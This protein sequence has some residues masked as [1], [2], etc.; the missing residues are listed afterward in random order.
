MRRTCTSRGSERRI[1]SVAASS[2]SSQRLQTSARG[3]LH[4]PAKAGWK[5]H[6]IDGRRSGSTKSPS[7][8]EA[9][10]AA[11]LAL[12]PGERD[13]ERQRLVCDRPMAEYATGRERPSE[14]SRSRAY[15]S[16]RRWSPRETEGHRQPCRSQGL[17]VKRGSARGHV[18]RQSFGWASGRGSH[19]PRRKSKTGVIRESS[20]SQVLVL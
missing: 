19:C 14:G 16:E 17:A 3:A 12:P 5:G 6:G 13:R 15:R 7:F 10:V 1:E 4:H 11:N 18:V 2:T 20:G 8:D 9:A